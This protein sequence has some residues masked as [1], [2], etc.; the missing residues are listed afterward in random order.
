MSKNSVLR[1]V[2]RALLTALLVT[3]ALVTATSPGTS[4]ASDGCA[5]EPRLR[6]ASVNQGLEY[7]PLV[8][9]KSTLVRLY[10]EMPKCA[11]PDTDKIE[12]EAASLKVT[13]AATLETLATVTATPNPV[14]VYPIV[15]AFGVAPLKDSA[16]DPKF[17]IDGSKLAPPL[18]PGPFGI[19]L[20]ADVTYRATHGGVRS[21]SI[22]R[23]FTPVD[24]PRL[25][26]R[27]AGQS[28]PLRVLVVPMGNT[29]D[30]FAAEFP[31]G[32]ATTGDAYKT[33]TQGLRSLSRM[34]PVADGVTSPI[35][36]SSPAGVQ[37]SLVP[38]IA[39]DLA[40]IM[41]LKNKDEWFCGKAS[42]FTPI[43]DSLATA[44]ANW[45]SSNSGAKADVALG[46]VWHEISGSSA[47]GCAQGWA[48]VSSGEAWVRLTPGTTAAPSP[49]GALMGMEIAHTFA[50]VP[51]NRD[52]EGGHDGLNDRYHSEFLD[53]HRERNRAYDLASGKFIE[54]DRT[55]MK[56]V[57]QPAGWTE[58][59]TLY[60]LADWRMLHCYLTPGDVDGGCPV[61]GSVGTAGA[62][63]ASFVITGTTNVTATSDPALDRT[64]A[65][66]YFEAGPRTLADGDSPYTLV[67]RSASGGVVRSEG[68]TVRFK[69]SQHVEDG[70]NHEHHG[71]VADGVFEHVTE[72][73]GDTVARIELRHDSRSAPLYARD[74]NDAPIVQEKSFVSGSVANVSDPGDGDAPAITRDGRWIAYSD[75]TAGIRIRRTDLATASSIG[76]DGRDPAWSANGTRLA[77]VRPNGSL[78]V[79]SFDPSTGALGAERLVYDASLQNELKSVLGSAAASDPSWAPD[80]TRIAVQIGTTR[81][82]IFVL[83]S[84]RT[85]SDLICRYVA[86]PGAPCFPVTKD[87][88]S[89]T[90]GWGPQNRIA[91]VAAGQIVVYDAATAV[92][93]LT[94]ISGSR[95][96]WSND[97][98]VYEA[99]GSIWSASA[100]TYANRVR[101]TFAN[102]TRPSIDQSS[103]LLAV[104]RTSGGTTDAILVDLTKKDFTLRVSDEY[105]GDL[106]VDVFLEC[107]GASYP[108]ILAEKPAS[109]DGSVATFTMSY[110]PAPA[111]GGGELVAR[112]TDGY[113]VVRESLGTLPANP[114]GPGTPY[115]AASIYRPVSGGSSLQYEALAFSGF[116][117]DAD[118]A[119]SDDRLQW[120]LIH[121][122]G[123]SKVLGTGAQLGTVS[124]AKGGWA[125][126]TYTAVLEV[127]TSGGWSPRAQVQ[128]TILKDGDNDLRPPGECNEND[129][130][131][132]DAFGDSDGDGIP[133]V[134][135]DNPCVSANNATVKFD[136]QN[137]YVP[138]EGNDITLYVKS[139]AL[140][141]GNVKPS[142]VAIS[143]IGPWYVD[144]KA[145][146]WAYDNK[147]KQWVAKFGRHEVTKFMS[148][149]GLVDQFVP[150]VITGSDGT[151]T[152]RGFDP[153]YPYTSKS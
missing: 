54:D 105:P 74:I 153:K 68:V 107:T 79:R 119:V 139:G 4:A 93:T 56:F 47:D 143:K 149:K 14:E 148:D 122:D 30:G 100:T 19:V 50:A 111:C 99:G 115:P 61:P 106:R 64:E 6:D 142:T 11:N 17:L 60:E 16:G 77:Y 150:V 69:E 144:F 134:D 91:Y 131:P 39:V 101:L 42:N 44:L 125:V 104:G 41:T 32:D 31:G 46:V 121:P 88:T 117:L 15:A 85:A 102:D 118:G 29:A 86:L 92:A 21:G 48:S 65:H 2:L 84:S 51:E 146:S 13:H 98:L 138:S 132:R 82:D 7:S 22:T 73:A 33:V 137:L 133:D 24:N 89:S 10:L 35:K 62:N 52:D 147:S 25:A 45:N 96:A 95:P 145:K 151:K 20:T 75:P 152:F 108:V 9:G 141:L 49:T 71:E 76:F 129:A 53:A 135:D 72:V 124:P 38:S 59:N 109:I 34:L 127:L 126:G 55:V 18:S 87:Q 66:S 81:S 97:L 26:A 114:G 103:S 37:F 123:T 113:R 67:Q 27:V 8:R 1:R 112:I 63:Q 3:T 80:S 28:N 136:P 128:F 110:D 94:T 12:I 23:T 5:L 130:N 140:D 83:D 58:N 36:A 43:K 116:A 90:P 70:H 78:Y 57:G 120:R 40:P